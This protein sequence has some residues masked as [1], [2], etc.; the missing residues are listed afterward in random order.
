MF[1]VQ[2]WIY[3]D[4]AWLWFNCSNMN[5]QLNGIKFTNGDFFG[6]LDFL[7]NFRLDSLSK[8]K[9]FL[10]FLGISFIN[11]YDPAIVLALYRKNFV[12]INEIL[13]STNNYIDS[14]KYR[15]YFWVKI[16]AEKYINNNIYF[17]IVISK[18]WNEYLPIYTCTD[19]DLSWNR[20][21]HIVL[22]QQNGQ[23]F[24]YQLI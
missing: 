12:L 20:L 5:L 1:T 11:I 22:L 16:Q 7:M 23:S 18:E 2:A 13:A 6:N 19:F 14:T 3:S 10:W 21:E 4:N 24:M 9:R 15:L 8:H 17:N